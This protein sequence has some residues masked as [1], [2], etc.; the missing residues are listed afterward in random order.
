VP[1][2][3][4]HNY[5]QV[6][7][8]NAHGTYED[9]WSMGLRIGDHDGSGAGTAARAS[10]V[11]LNDLAADLEAWWTGMATAFSTTT[12]MLGFKFNGVDVEGRYISNTATIQRTF[13]ASGLAGTSS[14]PSLPPQVSCVVS[15]LSPAA[16]GLASKGRVY[17]P[18]FSVGNVT[19][20]G[21]LPLAAAQT[22]QDQFATL[23]TNLGNWPGL[24]AAQDAGAPM[25]ASKVRTGEA[26]PITACSVGTVLDTQ[27]RR[28]S[29][30]KEVRNDPTAVT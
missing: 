9:I 2:P 1:F 25:V 21:V 7:G 15:L 22:I 11:H 12:K 8:T 5:L 20:G 26:R 28:R 27:R 3:T 18:P 14:S 17:L 24:D 4:A 13:G 10:D 23:L 6:Y 30:F 16:R 19:S 29:A